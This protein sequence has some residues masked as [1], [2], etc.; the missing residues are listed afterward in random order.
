MII[1]PN[2]IHNN[3]I[4]LKQVFGSKNLFFQED[5]ICLAVPESCKLPKSQILISFF[6][7]NHSYSHPLLDAC[8]RKFNFDLF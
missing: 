2:D 4:A 5:N 6:S 8:F 3:T 7:H 1:E